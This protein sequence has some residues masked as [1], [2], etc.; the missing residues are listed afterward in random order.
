M[1]HD[2]HKT[3][4][5]KEFDFDAN[6][7]EIQHLFDFGDG[8]Q[9]ED[10]QMTS[11]NRQEVRMERMFAVILHERQA[12]RS[13]AASLFSCEYQGALPFEPLETEDL[14]ARTVIESASAA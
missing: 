1:P 13:R 8:V 10:V 14:D 3:M 12:E 6:P 9:T 2:Y 7:R 5:Q 4:R 11:K